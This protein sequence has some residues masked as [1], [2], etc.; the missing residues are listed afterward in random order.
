MDN[1]PDIIQANFGNFLTGAIVAILQLIIVYLWIERRVERIQLRSEAKKWKDARKE[2]DATLVSLAH[3]LVRPIAY[4]TLSNA[5]GVYFRENYAACLTHIIDKNA[6]LDAML[7]IYSVG[8]EPASLTKITQLADRLRSTAG[9]AG[10]ALRNL[11]E[12]EESFPP[13][14]ADEAVMITGLRRATASIEFEVPKEKKERHE[15]LFA[16]YVLQLVSDIALISERMSALA[17]SKYEVA[18]LDQTSRYERLK[19]MS[20]GEQTAE[21][22][23]ARTAES[24]SRLNALIEVME[25][26]GIRLAFAPEVD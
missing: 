1:L 23:Q 5:R 25:R 6:A 12:I 19:E 13:Q 8:L 22:D 7:A 24:I 4:Y 11:R 14:A 3:T 17:L 9:N 21:L 16:Y 26:Q 18:E 10:T 2:L 20:K 15:K